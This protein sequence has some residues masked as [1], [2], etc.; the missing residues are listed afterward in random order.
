M[1]ALTQL[2]RNWHA[3]LETSVNNKTNTLLN[4]T[5]YMFM[6]GGVAG[7][8]RDDIR[9]NGDRCRND[10]WVTTDGT[11]WERVLPP[12]GMTTMPFGARAWHACVTW[13]NPHDRSR[14]VITPNTE[15]YS[16]TMH[17]QKL[18]HPRMYITGGGYT[19]TK[20]NNIVRSLEG[21]IDTW[22]STDGSIWNRID[23][24]EGRKDSLYSTNEWSLLTLD[25]YLLYLGKWGH[26]LESFTP[27][28]DLNGDGEIS[29]TSTSLRFCGNQTNVDT[30][31]VFSVNEDAFPALLLIGGDT[32]DNGPMVND[33]FISRPGGKV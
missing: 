16:G 15:G 19:G 28:E 14:A 33:V 29:N 31:R 11:E 26:T 2:R 22:W 12:E 30:C 21:Y 7:W 13:H 23:Y 20:G 27:Q 6:V 18:I 1:C 3:P 10:V 17:D 9:Y 25:N 5:E 4:V 32:V 24:E 8:P